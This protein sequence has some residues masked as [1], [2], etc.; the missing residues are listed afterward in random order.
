[1]GVIRACSSFLKSD[2]SDSLLLLFSKGKESESLLTK[3]AKERFALLK[4]AK[5][6]ITLFFKK[7]S[8]FHEKQRANSQPWLII[9]KQQTIKF[10]FFK[11]YLGNHVSQQRNR[12]LGENKR[13]NEISTNKQFFLPL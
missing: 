13:Y 8:N 6:R 3:R 12:V 1:M 10:S 2:R 9:E 7:T 11:F 5:V 4:R